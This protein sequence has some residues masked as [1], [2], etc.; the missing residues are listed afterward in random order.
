MEIELI[1]SRGRNLPIRKI[2]HTT[3]GDLWNLS[4]CPAKTV[5]SWSRTGKVCHRGMRKNQRREILYLARLSKITLFIWILIKS[6]LRWE[7]KPPFQGQFFSINLNASQTAAKKCKLGPSIF[8]SE[9]FFLQLFLSV[10]VW[11][12]SIGTIYENP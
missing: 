2:Y 6:W 8:V 3:D 7:A 4:L 1:L 10:A 5:N 9:N 12:I 11:W